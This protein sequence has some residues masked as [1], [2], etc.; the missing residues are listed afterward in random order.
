MDKSEALS[1]VTPVYN[2]AR[3]RGADV[4]AVV[5]FEAFVSSP[6]EISL[7]FVGHFRF[8]LSLLLLFLRD[9]FRSSC[10]IVSIIPNLFPTRTKFEINTAILIS[11][12]QVLPINTAEIH[13]TERHR[14]FSTSD[15]RRF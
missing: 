10:H 9:R 14:Y 1:K 4:K 2:G 12:E 13:A 11:K 3:C 8:G 7:V 15:A 6:P 5:A